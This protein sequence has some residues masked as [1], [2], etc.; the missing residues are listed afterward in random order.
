[1]ISLFG[2]TGFNGLT[3]YVGLFEI[4]KPRK[5]E[6]VFVSAACGSVGIWWVSMQKH[7]AAMWQEVLEATIRSVVSGSFL[8]FL[9]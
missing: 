4:C 5:G 2:S 9:T 6:R 1:M 8:E 3:A 7:R